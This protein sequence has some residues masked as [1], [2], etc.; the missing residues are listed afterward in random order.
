MS[1]FRQNAWQSEERR[2]R[3][4]DPPNTV[5]DQLSNMDDLG[6]WRLFKKGKE[7]ALIFIYRNYVDVL[8]NY[9]CQFTKK[10]ELVR[11]TVQEF[12]IELINNKHNLSDT[13]SIKYYLFKSFRR[14][15]VRVLNKESR[16]IKE[17]ISDQIEGFR[18]SHDPELRF[19]KDQMDAEQ[20]RVLKEKFNALPPKQREAL[21]L[22][23][24]EG[25]SY[26]EIAGLFEMSKVKSARVLIYRA[27]DNLAN[28]LKHFRG[29][30]ESLVLVFSYLH[31]L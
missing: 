20:K 16:V 15:L 18:I 8:F 30:I 26:E 24:Y 1:E 6:I 13:D 19:I 5:K 2:K 22:Y 12:F 21:L 31:I 17:E 11:D 10:R 25:L 9:G 28:E 29:L 23:Y 7:E 4:I 27:I 14:K 3:Q